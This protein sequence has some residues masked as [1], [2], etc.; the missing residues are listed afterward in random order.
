MRSGNIN[1]PNTAG[2]FRYAGSIGFEWSSRASSS[3]LAYW[4]EFVDTESRPSWGPYDR[5]RGFP[6]RCPST[7][8]DI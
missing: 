2:V 5:F 7:V 6:L 1:L 3:T 4:L 8:L